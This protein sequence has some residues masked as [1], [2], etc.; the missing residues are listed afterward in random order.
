[1]SSPV[2]RT[3]PQAGWTFRISAAVDRAVCCDRDSGMVAAMFAL[4]GR[5]SETLWEDFELHVAPGQIVAVAGPSGAGKSVLLG[6]L[7]AAAPDAVHL[8]TAR[9]ARS[10][11]PAVRALRGGTLAR[12]LEVL[13]RC[14]L[15]EAAALITPARNLSGGQRYRLALAAALHTALRR[16]H[17]GG[18]ATLVLADEFASTLDAATAEVLC[19]QVRTLI[20][21]SPVALVLATPRI[22]LLEALRADRVMVK[23]LGEPV[24][25][26]PPPHRRTIRRGARHWPITPGSI[27]D[28]DELGAFHYLAG[29]PAA[30]KRVYVV[31]A[32]RKVTA[33]GGPRTAAVLV[34]SPPLANCRGRNAATGGRYN[35]PDRAAAMELLNRE[36]ECVSRVVVHP[37]FRGCGLAVR[38]VRRAVARAEAPLMEALAAMGQMHPFFER[39]GMWAWPQ[40]PDRHV[41]RFIAAV[42]A[43]GLAAEQIPAVAPVRRL[44]SRR[45]RAARFLRR[46]LDLCLRRTFST[47]Q[48]S[49]MTDADAELCRRSARRPV[50]YLART[51][52]FAHSGGRS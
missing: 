16:S 35:G 36:V 44:L 28:Y 52:Q 31:R 19:R 38:L 27:G 43:V 3:Q 5:W 42:E 23:P 25:T 18:P 13:S 10:L 34:V 26:V 51:P 49:R 15:A 30:H 41:V 33:G 37:M 14:G 4:P 47:A 21:G 20:D 40:G 11:V 9:L 45:T 24:R 8:P 12:R 22:E 17:G 39:A 48:L 6:R 32:P 7:A 2:E 46:E 50:Y 1:M 29:R